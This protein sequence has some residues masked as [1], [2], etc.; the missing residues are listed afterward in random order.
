MKSDLPWRVGRQVGRTI[1]DAHDT[2]IGV[3]DTREMAAMVVQ[4]VN[5]T[6]SG[7][8]ATPN[9]HGVRLISLDEKRLALWQA[10]ES[11][12]IGNKTDDKSI[13]NHLHA[14]GYTI[15]G[16]NAA[17]QSSVNGEA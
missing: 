14:A 3:M 5:A 17:S 11:I 13:I 7:D 8:A 2:L 4:A 12:Q 15:V 6:P 9:K 10:I 1:Y 16:I